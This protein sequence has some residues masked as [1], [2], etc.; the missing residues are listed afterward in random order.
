MLIYCRFKNFCENFIS[1]NSIKRHIS[2]VKNSRLRQELPIS[3]KDRVILPFWEGFIFT[4]LHISE[5][6]VY[7]KYGT[8]HCVLLGVT[9]KIYVSGYRCVSDCNSRG[10]EFDPGPVP[11]FRGD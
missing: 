8:A 2:D 1:A 9:C 10:R 7:S 3:I 5:F 6:T 4:K 11:Y